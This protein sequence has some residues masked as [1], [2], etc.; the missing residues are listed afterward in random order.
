LDANGEYQPTYLA[1]SLLS[2]FDPQISY[3][4]FF[5][6]LAETNTYKPSIILSLELLEIKKAAERVFPEA[7]CIFPYN[8]HDEKIISSEVLSHI[9]SFNI[10][11]LR[12]G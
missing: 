5:K 7:E 9:S 3:L 10:R 1:L 8:F 2:Q 11:R 12:M 4:Q 6:I